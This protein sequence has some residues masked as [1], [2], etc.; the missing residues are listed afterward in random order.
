MDEEKLPG[1]KSEH[2]YPA[3][4]GDNLDDTYQLEVKLGYG[5]TSTVWLAKDIREYLAPSVL[6]SLTLTPVRTLIPSQR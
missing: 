6:R 5:T 1:Y 3:N 4:P 2:Y